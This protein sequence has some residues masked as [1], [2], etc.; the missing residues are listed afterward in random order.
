MHKN[1][2]YDGDLLAQLTKVKNYLN[3]AK[4]ITEAAP[5]ELDAAQMHELEQKI[6][7]IN[8]GSTMIINSQLPDKSWYKKHGSHLQCFDKHIA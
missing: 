6:L 7:L 3:G 8:A 2:A 4:A 5:Y 1:N